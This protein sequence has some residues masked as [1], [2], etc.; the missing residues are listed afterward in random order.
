MRGYAHESTPLASGRCIRPRHWDARLHALVGA[1]PPRRPTAGCAGC[2]RFADHGKL[3]LLI[4][5]LLG[6]RRAR[7]A[8]ARSAG[9]ARW[10]S[11]PLVNAVLK[12]FFGRVR[13]DLANLQSHRPLARPRDAVVPERALGFGRAFV[14]GVAMESP[15]AGA[16]LAP[17]ALGVGYSRVHVGVHYPGRRRRRARRGQRGRRGHPALVAGAAEGPGAGPDGVRGPGAARRRRAGGH[18]QP[19]LGHRRLRPGRGHRRSSCRRRGP[20][21][22]RGGRRRRAARRGGAVRAGEGAR[23]GRR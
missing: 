4:G 13:P 7:C 23:R 5:A 8:G 19:A 15:V 16:A 6:L 22:E 2:P 9:S 14:T 1:C 10:R 3:W 12:Q 20:G 21:A 18:R 11:Q 17:L